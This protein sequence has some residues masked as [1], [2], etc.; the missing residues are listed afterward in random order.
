MVTQCAGAPGAAT[1]EA[2]PMIAPAVR[3][4]VAAGNARVIISLR[5]TPPFKPEGDLPG[6]AAVEAQR[7]AIAETQAEVLGRLRGT[8]FALVRQYDAVPTLALL[9]D[10]DALARLEAAGDV[11]AKVL[12]D[13][14]LLRQ[15]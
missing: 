1:G 14:P 11:V 4:A 6:P 12:P 8:K 3:A 7:K 10:A 13:A 9:I 5:I 2:D 15:Q